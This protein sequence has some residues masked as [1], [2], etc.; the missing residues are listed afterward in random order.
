[1]REITPEIR[2]RYERKGRGSIP[3][4]VNL[5]TGPAAPHMAATEINM[6][7][8]FKRLEDMIISSMK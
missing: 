1:M 7:Y 6:R 8:D 3:C 5:I 2:S 4:N